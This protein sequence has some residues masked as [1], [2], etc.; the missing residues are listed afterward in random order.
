MQLR[1]DHP[2][3]H[4]ISLYFEC[5]VLNETEF[6]SFITTLQVTLSSSNRGELLM[7][8]VD[9]GKNGGE[10]IIRCTDEHGILQT[11]NQLKPL[12]QTTTFFEYGYATL[13]LPTKSGGY[14]K[15]GESFGMGSEP[16]EDTDESQA[17]LPIPE[18][19][20]KL[21]S[22]GLTSLFSRLFNPR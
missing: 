10:F 20:E 9:E 19:V 18:G 14:K 21:K 8:A 17:D 22:G 4:H 11:L 6:D 13:L 5:E 16:R 2:P 7:Y 1:A 3:N 12:L 15:E